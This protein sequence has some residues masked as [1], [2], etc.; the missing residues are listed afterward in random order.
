MKGG[1][2]GRGGRERGGWEEGE[3]VELAVVKRASHPEP[4][5][6]DETL[7]LF[8]EFVS[9]HQLPPH[10]VDL[11][12]RERREWEDFTQKEE[13]SLF[14]PRNVGLYDNY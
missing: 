12:V 9:K 10:A 4:P 8:E 13:Q 6:A 2:G 7:W 3:E 1:S 11:E 5:A 14:I